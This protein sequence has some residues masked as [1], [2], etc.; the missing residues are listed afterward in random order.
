MKPKVDIIRVQGGMYAY[1]VGT[2][3]AVAASAD[4]GFGLMEF[5]SLERCLS[6]AGDVLVPYFARIDVQ[7]GGRYLGSCSTRYMCTAPDRLAARIRQAA[8]V[9]VAA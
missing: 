5:D 1:S 8:A 7:F 6:D 3:A 4:G 2:G 9:V